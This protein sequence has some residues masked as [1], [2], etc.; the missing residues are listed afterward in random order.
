MEVDELL[1]TRL[2]IFYNMLLAAMYAPRKNLE[3]SHI[4]KFGRKIGA[5]ND[6]LDSKATQKVYV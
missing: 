1:C 3:K 5:K 2:V 6:H 4:R